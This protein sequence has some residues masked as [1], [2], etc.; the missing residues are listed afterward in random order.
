MGV[1]IR[2]EDVLNL[3]KIRTNGK[4]VVNLHSQWFPVV[5][6]PKL[7]GIVA[8]LMGDGHLQG[9]KLWRID[10]TSKDKLELRRFESTVFSLFGVRGK[11]RPCNGNK[12]G[13][14]FNIGINNKLLARILFLVGVPP[15]CKVKTKF[16]IP[17]WI[18]E[19][20]EYFRTFVRRLFT[21]EGSVSLEGSNSFIE[22]SM[23]KSEALLENSF[24]FFKQIKNNLERYFDIQ[25]M[26]IFT[27]GHNIRKDGI[28]TIGLK[29]RIKKLKFLI[30]FRDEI[31]FEDTIKQDKLIKAIKIKI[32]NS[33]WD[34][35]S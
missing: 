31:G 33:R 12:F 3:F 32:N 16:L 23:Y 28:K 8:D 14:T 30:G 7:A 17:N 34:S 29:L 4:K 11:I 24:D 1:L 20:K 9:F 6:S 25:T 15:G 27:I 21:C 18:L 2:K 5:A 22:M 13:K 35:I 19:D 26:D 10:F